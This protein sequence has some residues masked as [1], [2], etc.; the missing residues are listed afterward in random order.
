MSL[1]ISKLLPFHIDIFEGDFLGAYAFQLDN[2]CMLLG[3]DGSM[4]LVDA[5]L[6]NCIKTREIDDELAMVLAQHK[7]I[8]F[9]SEPISEHEE[10]VKPV[11]FM[12]DLTNR[13]NM[14][15]KYCLREG[16]D[17]IKAKVMTQ[18]KLQEVCDYIIDYCNTNEEYY[19][20]VQP[21]GGEPLLERDKIFFIQDYLLSHGI[22]PSISIET[23]GTLLTE[24]LIKELHER[25]IWVSVSIDGPKQIHD[26]QRVFRGGQP[27][28]SSVEKNLI[29]LS[30]IYEGN[31]SIIATI[32]KYT[33][34]DVEK[35]LRYLVADLNLSNIKINFVHK[36]SFVD[37]DEMCMTDDEIADCTIKILETLVNLSEKGYSVGE[38][39]IYTKIN[40]LVY[41][42]KSDVCICDGCHGGRKMLTLDYQG[43]IYPCDVSDYPEERLGNIADNDNLVELIENSMNSH[44]Y[45]LIKKEKKCN[46]CPWYCYCRGG[47]TVHVKT[48][49]ENPPK[50]DYIECSINHA[51]YPRLIEMILSKPEVINK[52][53]HREAL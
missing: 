3:L 4:L 45:F 51:L 16:E 35:I 33:Y 27:T 28:H 41:N 2:K 12:I 43:D 48:Q 1:S 52:L 49:G 21:W 5:D 8:S 53:L 38:Y 7:L 20:T 6:Y 44:P 40:N 11:F 29:K 19:I 36:S 18:D 30:E 26:A 32:T 31:V 22:Q 46:D 24:E 10:S 34:Q 42:R 9:N 47:C 23:N 39:N 15:C 17:S 50:T 13:C 37:N 25:N 14:A